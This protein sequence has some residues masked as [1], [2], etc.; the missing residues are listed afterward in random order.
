MKQRLF[1]LQS[2]WICLGILLTLLFGIRNVAGLVLP[3]PEM[4]ISNERSFLTVLTW[5]TMLEFAWLLL[6]SCFF[7]RSLGDV[8]H[9]LTW[10]V[11]GFVVWF[12]TNVLGDSSSAGLSDNGLKDLYICA[13]AAVLIFL[14]PFPAWMGRFPDG[15]YWRLLGIYL[16][17]PVWDFGSMLFPA[18]STV[19]AMCGLV[20]YGWFLDR[21]FTACLKALEDSDKSAVHAGG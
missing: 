19:S 18:V 12:I 3:D 2:L 16:I 8:V 15:S 9:N 14:C 21:R 13:V 5:L 1:L 6:F 7:I 4:P 11:I 17:F 10:A 20:I